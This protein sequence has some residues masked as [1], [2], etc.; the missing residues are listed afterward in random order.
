MRRA[1]DPRSLAAATLLLAL[2]SA[3]VARADAPTTSS[4]VSANE[5]AIALR[6]ANKLRA[7]EEASLACSVLACPRDVRN[8]CSKR[9]AEL[10]ALVPTV[11]FELKDAQGNDV[12]GVAVTI[13]GQPVA[14]RPES[15]AIAADPGEHTFTFTAPGQPAVEKRLVLSAGALGRHEFVVLGP[16]KAVVPAGSESAT[17]GLGTRKVAALTVGGLGVVGVVVGSVFGALTYSSWSSV[18]S[19]CGPGGAS[20]CSGNPTA[21]DADRSG[22]VTDGAASTV[23]FV[24][25]G[26]R[27]A[28]GVV[29]FL[30]GGHRDTGASAAIVPSVGPGQAGLVVQGAF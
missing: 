9:A 2:A 4:C 15:P 19:A 16:P 29:L 28:T 20:R 17:T 26:A 13:D 25:G 6:Y 22:A 3:S 23:A 12:T 5:R 24:V 30:T 10:H 11:V 7:S 21:V 1:P 8:V 18:G 27:I 14:E